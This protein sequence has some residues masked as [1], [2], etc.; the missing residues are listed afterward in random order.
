MN[1]KDIWQSISKKHV[2]DAIVGAIDLISDL[3]VKE[4]LTYADAIK[5][6]VNK[7]PKD[8]KMVKGAILRKPHVKGT[9]I[10]LLGLDAKDQP[11]H[12]LKI[13]AKKIDAELEHA[14]GTTDLIIVE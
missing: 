6:L 5:S 11:I 13:I 1:L 4:E 7:L 12:G 10:L 9:E 3:G 2:K 14:F 8:S